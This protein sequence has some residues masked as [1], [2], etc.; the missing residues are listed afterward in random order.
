[1]PDKD[2]VRF[3]EGIRGTINNAV[4]QMPTHQE[5]LDRHCRANDDVWA[6]AAMR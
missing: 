6:R 1:M 3:L 5:F 4:S 2:L